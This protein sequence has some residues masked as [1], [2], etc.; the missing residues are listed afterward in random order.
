MNINEYKINKIVSEKINRLLREDDKMSKHKH[1]VQ[2]I[3]D[4]RFHD[5]I[6]MPGGLKEQCYSLYNSNKGS[7]ILSGKGKSKIG[8]DDAHKYNEQKLIKIANSLKI[9]TANL[10]EI[11]AEYDLNGAKNGSPYIIKKFVVR[12]PYDSAHSISIVFGVGNKPI[13]VTAWI[14]RLD[15][16]HMSLNPNLYISSKKERQERVKSI[17]DMLNNNKDKI[18]K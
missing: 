8:C 16:N 10:F 15:D 13:I 3:Y 9:E 17:I 12:V 7:F 18:E 14:N 11:L 2:T 6:Y 5:S 4:F 1:S